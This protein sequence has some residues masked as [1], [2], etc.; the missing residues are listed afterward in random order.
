MAA[1]KVSADWVKAYY[2]D[3]NVVEHYRRAVANIGLWKSETAVFKRLFNSDDRIL[4][5]GAGT[6]RISIGLAELGYR[7]LLGIDLSREMIKDGAA[8]REAA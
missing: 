6:G 8:N 1:E 5:L 4:E 3:D 7:H 2:D